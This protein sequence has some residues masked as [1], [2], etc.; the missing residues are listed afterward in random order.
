MT[1]ECANF[2]LDWGRNM[3]KSFKIIMFAKLIVIMVLMNLAVAAGEPY[4]TDYNYT[5]DSE[6][7]LEQQLIGTWRWEA[8]NSFIIVFREDGTMLDGWP[9][10][11][12][13]YNWR[14]VDGRLIVN[15]ADWNIRFYGDA[16]FTVARYGQ[17]W[18]THTYAWYSDSTEGEPSLMILAI[19]GII[20]LIAVGV[21]VLAGVIVLVVLL[22]VRRNKR[23][24]QQEQL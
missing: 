20:I 13:I 24:K 12:T 17:S 19:F 11:R 9:W 21:L 23:R 14:A 7:S 3:K 10:L 18:N 2:T 5:A 6:I 8:D 16:M 4:Y 15:G 22:L 1:V